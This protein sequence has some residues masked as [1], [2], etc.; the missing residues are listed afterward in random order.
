M[1]FV[2]YVDHVELL[3]YWHH[4]SSNGLYMWPWA[5]TWKAKWEVGWT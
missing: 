3:V 5:N 4:G 2:T 1:S